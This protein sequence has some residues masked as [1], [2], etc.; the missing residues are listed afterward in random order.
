VTTVR[1]AR[2]PWVGTL[3]LTT[4]A[5]LAGCGPVATEEEMGKGGPRPDGGLAA[6]PD[7]GTT[8]IAF[9]RDFQD[10]GTWTRYVL[11]EAPAVGDGTIH[12]KGTRTVYV[13][14]LPPAGR[15]SFPVGTIIVK[16]METGETFARVKR[17]GGYNR[18][19]ALGWEWFELKRD[20]AAAAWTILWR[21]ITPPAGFCY[22]G[23][24][25]GAC[26]GCHL[27]FA[28]NDYVAA[29]VLDLAAL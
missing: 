28:D 11:T 8:F 6:D 3:L 19:G 2:P 18:N 22:G 9:Q 5:A 17:G 10:F 25:G 29:S 14:Q 27:P 16:T 12:G 4:L 21:G 15:H 1:E 20:E 7:E 23:I 24:A 26:N 13:N